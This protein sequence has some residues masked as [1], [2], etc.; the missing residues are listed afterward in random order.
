MKIKPLNRH[1]VVHKKPQK[2]N[3]Y[4]DYKKIYEKV[5]DDL[6]AG[7]GVRTV[8]QM[9]LNGFVKRSRGRLWTIGIKNTLKIC[10]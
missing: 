10:C 6:A 8:D 3:T 9:Q 5:K 1:L 2:K 7:L 4:V